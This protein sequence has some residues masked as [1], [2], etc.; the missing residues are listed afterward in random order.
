MLGTDR[1]KLEKKN[2]PREGDNGGGLGDDTSFCLV[3]SL[4]CSPQRDGTWILDFPQLHCRVLS[5]PTAQHFL[6]SL[7]SSQGHYAIK[8]A[9]FEEGDRKEAIWVPSCHIF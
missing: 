7:L 2:M 4:E 6:F 3:A 1:A 9:N 8:N 5:T